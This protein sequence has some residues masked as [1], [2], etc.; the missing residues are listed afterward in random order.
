MS[1]TVL[2][3]WVGSWLVISG[4]L[5]KLFDK[6][7]AATSLEVK[8]ALKTWLLNAKPG[9]KLVHWSATFGE[10]F[11]SVF[12]KR[13]LHGRCFLASTIASYLGV[14]IVT[15]LWGALRPDSLSRLVQS[16]G[17]VEFAIQSLVFATIMNLVPDYVSLLESRLIIRVIA[18]NPSVFRSLSLLA[19]DLVVTAAI[20]FCVVG[21]C[22][23]TAGGDFGD[24]IRTGVMLE[25]WG[26]ND[27]SPSVFFYS[28]FFTSVWVWLYVLSGICVKLGNS[29]SYLAERLRFIL[30]IKEKPFLSLGVVIILSIS[31]VYVAVFPFVL[32]I[33][34]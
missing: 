26:A 25:T 24:I 27:P 15:L 3:S 13:H 33:H 29:I 21:T 20:G 17:A 4:V 6:A 14:L 32:L 30:N 28:T 11:D 31:F 18:R 22:L 8:E 19:L 16:H 1:F 5:W 2:A 10:A 12:G 9:E 34:R 23:Y 7:E